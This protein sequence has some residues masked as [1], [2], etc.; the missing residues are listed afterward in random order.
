MKQTTIRIAVGAPAIRVA[1]PRANAEAATRVAREAAKLGA[2][3]LVLPELCLTAATAGVLFTRDLLITGAEEALRALI[4]ATADLDLLSF[5]GLPVRVGGRLYNCAAAV[6]G[7]RLLGLVPKTDPHDPYFSPA[8]QTD[9][10]VC[11]AGFSAS[12]AAGQIF[13]PAAMPALTVS[14]GVGEAALAPGASLGVIL[15]ADPEIAGREEDRANALLALSR[16]A[17]CPVA[18]A[19]AGEGESGADAVY[20]GHCLITDG[21]ALTAR[22]PFAAAEW[23]VADV[24]IPPCGVKEAFFCPFPPVKALEPVRKNPYLPEDPARAD[25]WCARILEIQAAGLAGRY[26]RAYAG[27]LVLGISGGLDS[28]LALLAAVRA[29]D[30]LGLPRETVLAVTMPC[31]GT[32]ARTKG[33][34]EKLCEALGVRLRTVDIHAAV[35]QH[36]ADIG[37]DERDLSVVY[38]NAQARERTQ[39]LMDIANGEGGLVV[40]TGDLSELALGWATYNGD[41]MSMYGVNAGLPKTLVRRVTDYA[42]REAE[43]N[44]RMGEAACLFDI[45]AT[46]VSPELLPPKDGEIAQKTEGL[47]GPYELHDFFLYY[48]VRGGFSPR[49]LLA[50]AED[51]FG[52]R[53]TGEEIAAWLRV[54]LRRFFSQ[55][56][57]RSCLP[58]GPQVG[59]ISL[60]PR[61]AWQMPSDAT[62]A[63]WLSD[64]DTE[65]ARRGW[66]L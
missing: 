24:N 33:N 34:A 35:R 16:R 26:T 45:F 11:V 31:F 20:A 54:F 42:A 66:T 8:P 28:T 36:F 59:E 5:V 51:A 39:I 40:G 43:K 3:V 4:L 52:A 15:L 32:T 17:G 18:M 65:L 13:S 55:Q 48:F 22:S 62:A 57:K 19:N 37:H 56:F 41:H 61:G 9:L 50:A 64:L 49:A 14:V 53:Y 1:D 63:L 2:Q 47:V 58:D 30:R 6:Q 44:G 7:G 38:E 29:V 12:L 25:A 23:V 27:S 21:A 10:S 60:S 46:P